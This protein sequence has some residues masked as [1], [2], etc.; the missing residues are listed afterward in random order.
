MK[1]Y[2]SF[3]SSS[4]AIVAV[5]LM[6]VPDIAD[7]GRQNV[8]ELVLDGEIVRDGSQLSLSL[9]SETGERYR[10]NLQPED[11]N[12]ILAALAPQAGKE[13]AAG[14]KPADSE[15]PAKPAQ[16]EYSSS[17]DGATYQ[18]TSTDRKVKIEESGQE[19]SIE[20]AGDVV[21]MAAKMF[22]AQS[23]RNP[24]TGSELFID[25][26]N[27]SGW[28]SVGSGF[29]LST[30]AFAAGIFILF[31]AGLIALA[32]I[33]RLRKQKAY[34]VKMQ[35]QAIKAREEERRLLAAE[36]HDG[37]VQELQYLVRSV[38]KEGALH[39]REDEVH[40]MLD[41]VSGTLRKICHELRPPILTH[42]GLESAMRWFTDE[43]QRRNSE[44]EIELKLD[45][46]GK[47]LNSDQELA[48]FRIMQESLNNISKH[49][50]ASRVDVDL[51]IEDGWA[52][53]LITD[54]GDGFD[55]PRNFSKLA[56]DGHLGLLGITQ[57]AEAIGAGIE[58][59]SQPNEGTTVRVVTQLLSEN[60]ERR[61]SSSF[62]KA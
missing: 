28:V 26:A 62:M 5:L 58:F 19:A 33:L 30:I 15:P 45:C 34:L 31:V 44:L 9:S 12:R 27:N 14:V 24:E 6:F 37:P 41:T 60:A 47:L 21:L 35:Q 25:V 1:R 42:F 39:N 56:V 8:D 2:I 50:N 18:I 3:A 55:V 17:I 48:F 54:N 59:K 11:V 46:N 20:V 51:S 32:I 13:Q 43:F 7:F 49:A 38:T 16:G 40:H 4:F 22:N 53:L 10:V 36:L 57:R 61:R 29:R 52:E 23:G